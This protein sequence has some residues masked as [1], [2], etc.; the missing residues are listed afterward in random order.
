M[1]IAV[2]YIVSIKLGVATTLAVTFHEI[3]QELGDFGV[4]VYGG[5]SKQKALFYNFIC[6]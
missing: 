3:P 5:F 1:V 6:A 4:L 2:S